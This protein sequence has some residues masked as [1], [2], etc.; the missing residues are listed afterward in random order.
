MV[1][2]HT[3]SG[4]ERGK[5]I[6][7]MY[8]GTVFNDDTVAMTTNDQIRPPPYNTSGTQNV[9][10]IHNKCRKMLSLTQYIHPFSPTEPTQTTTTATASQCKRNNHNLPIESALPS[11]LA[12]GVAESVA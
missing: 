5:K 11:I 1:A 7:Y 3:K 2:A 10:S 9:Q 4:E 12:V 8:I 6:L